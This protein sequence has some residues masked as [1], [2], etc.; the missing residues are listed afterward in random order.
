M[1]VCSA[2]HR[3]SKPRSSSAFPSS[4]GWIESAVGKIAAPNCIGPPPGQATSAA[5]EVTRSLTTLLD[6]PGFIETP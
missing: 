4:A 5:G 6:P 1:W 2:T 3:D